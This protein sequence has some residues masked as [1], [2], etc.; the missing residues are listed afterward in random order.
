MSEFK[1]IWPLNHTNDFVFTPSSRD[2]FVEEIPLY[3][4]SGEGEHLVLK[5][6]KKNLTTWEMIDIISNYLGIKKKEIGYAGLKDK[7]AI[8]IQ[9]ISLP[10][11]YKE[12]LKR[13]E[14]KDIKILEEFLHNN[15]I[16]VGHLK[17]NRFWLRFKKVLDTQKLKIEKLLE[18]VE[19]NGMPNYFGVQRFGNSG[20]NYL[21]GKALVEGKM[22]LRDKKKREFLISSYQSFLF[23]S[24]LAKRIELSNLLQD[25]SEKEVENI[26]HFE[27]GALQGI[28][29]QK[30]YFKLLN[31]DLFMHYPYGKIFFEEL[32]LASKRFLQ[33][34]ISPTGLLPG[35]KV[36]LAQNLAL[37]LEKEYNIPI[38]E[39]GSRRYMWIFPE[40]ISFK[41]IPQNAWFEVS[42]FLPKGSYATV[43]VDFLKGKR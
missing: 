40:D 19:Q 36:K 22:K 37:E 32:E 41:Y 6:R 18:W 16:R 27:A 11:K 3:E 13:L 34:D 4:F 14:H 38:R 9:Y 21:E 17:G 10:K 15:K 12:K 42:F 43:L 26:F 8:T 35:K 5:I 20:L 29:K 1:Y 24:L 30:N 31:G 39:N 23:N 33:K 25:F 2:F 7:N 28:K